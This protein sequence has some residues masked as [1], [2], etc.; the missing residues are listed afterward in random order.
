MLDGALRLA[1]AAATAIALGLLAREHLLQ[2]APGIDLWAVL[3]RA[4]ALCGFP[5]IAY[6]ALARLLGV[7][8]IAEIANMALHTLRLQRPT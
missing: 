6:M 2:W 4:T 5:I 7:R 8:E 1:A 3:L